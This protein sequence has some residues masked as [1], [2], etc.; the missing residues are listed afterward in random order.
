MNIILNEKEYAEE[1]LKKNDPIDQPAYMI[2]LL[3]RYYYHCKGLRNAKI[4]KLLIDFLDARYPAYVYNKDAWT[5]R[6]DV[7]IARAKKSPPHEIDGI[8]IT[9]AELITIESLHNKVLERLAFSLLCFAKL[10]NKRSPKNNG[11]IHADLRDV[12]KTARISDPQEQ[13]YFRLNALYT[14]GLIAFPSKLDNPSFRVT[15]INDESPDKLFISDFREL[16][17][18][19][20]KYKGE[21][22]IRCGECGILVRG[23]KNGTKLYCSDCLRDRIYVPPMEV[24]AKRC[25][26]C[27]DLFEVS[28]KNNK[29]TRCP[30]CRDVRRR[31]IVRKSTQKWRNKDRM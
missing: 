23:N 15:F 24:K 10:F 27:G 17:Y 28:A 26:D 16:G 11:W 5:D 2:S 19:Y 7:A 9:E 29:S 13:R 25:I 14:A 4:S 3:A 1:C 21:N 20:L 6:I 8:W 31:E 30:H 12:F 22:F 18:E